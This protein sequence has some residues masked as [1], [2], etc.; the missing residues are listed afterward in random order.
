MRK[1]IGW[2]EYSRRLW[3]KSILYLI[4]TPL[5]FLGLV[6]YQHPKGRRRAK[7]EKNHNS[8]NNCHY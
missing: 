1:M 2:Q 5:T 3:I 8:S 6:F 7:T 4:Y